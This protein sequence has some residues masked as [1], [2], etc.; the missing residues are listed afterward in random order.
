MSDFNCPTINCALMMISVSDFSFF[1]ILSIYP[2]IVQAWTLCFGTVQYSVFCSPLLQMRACRERWWPLRERGFGVMLLMFWFCLGVEIHGFDQCL[3]VVLR[4]LK[5]RPGIV[6]F[7]ALLSSVTIVSISEKSYFGM[8]N[9]EVPGRK[10][11]Q[12]WKQLF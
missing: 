2:L 8:C 5:L 11:I 10:P 3:Y 12:T 9:G 6:L 4:E 7:S 1:G